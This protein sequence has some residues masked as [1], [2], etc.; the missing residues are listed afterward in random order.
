MLIVGLGTYVL[1]SLARLDRFPPVGQDEPW[2]AAAPY[3]LATEGVYG[4]DLF[5][6]YYGMDR[7]NYEHMPVFPLMEAGVFRLLGVDRSGDGRRSVVVQMRLL[8]VACG[9]C[10]LLCVF[11]VARQVGGEW[12]GALAVVLMTLLRVSAS[13]STG[14]GIL[15]L[16]S[17]RINRYDI[18]VPVFALMALW[19]LIGAE[20]HDVAPDRGRCWKYGM[21]GAFV[22]LASLAHL[23]GIFW[24]PV[25]IGIVLARGRGSASSL[26]S[27]GLMVLG[28]ALT[29][30]PWSVYVSR[31][32]PDFVGQTRY[33]R[34]R[35]AVFDPSFLVSNALHGPGPISFDWARRAI[36]GL[37]VRRVGAWTTMVGVPAALLL[38]VREGL[39]G[40]DAASSTR[41]PAHMIFP[42]VTVA[43]VLMFAAL[44]KVKTVHYMIGIWPLAMV[45]V[46]WCGVW[47]WNRPASRRGLVRAALVV[48]LALIAAEGSVGLS[49]ARE[50][51]EQASPYDGFESQIARCIPQGSL[52]LGL[53][54]YWLGL[55]QYRFRSWLVPIYLANS[56]YVD[57]PVGFDRA[58]ERVHPDVLLIDRSIREMFD[59][60]RRSDRQPAH[61]LTA[62]FDVYLSRHR[63]EPICVI[64][65]VT[66][67]TMEVYQ[68]H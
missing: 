46:A 13:T 20:R 66:Y 1:F 7:H 16:D 32:W 42:V 53:Q 25:F 49:R 56:Q 26:R 62:G 57:A 24:L 54:H 64:R 36:A 8:P 45:A 50:A 10:L 44:L 58:I 38:M 43:L 55:R 34:P 11:V 39:A 60:G 52:V 63:V 31:D 41:D 12:A 4:S 61:D 33:M 9:F 3:T 35:M 17:A 48:W 29:W 51:A 30:L 21:A 5:A 67:G 23:F 47:L 19:S 22:G 15:L 28:F 37:P 18:A 65:D 59:D 2:I 27:C 6:G 40:R 14:S 68:V